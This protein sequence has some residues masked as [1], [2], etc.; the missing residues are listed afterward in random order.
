M[1]KDE[2]ITILALGTTLLK[3][4]FYAS[5]VA[6]LLDRYYPEDLKVP[7]YLPNV[8]IVNL[9]VELVHCWCA[10]DGLDTYEP[11]AIVPTGWSGWRYQ[12]KGYNHLEIKLTELRDCLQSKQLPLPVILSE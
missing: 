10:E 1:L 11:G 7:L 3:E 6:E 2:R 4:P 12:R 8:E 9:G 5:N